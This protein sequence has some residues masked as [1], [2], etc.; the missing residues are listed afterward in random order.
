MTIR[1]FLLSMAAIPALTLPAVHAAV[2]YQHSFS[3]TSGTSLNGIALESRSGIAGGN[4][5]ATW[6][7]S[8]NIKADGSIVSPSGQTSMSAYVPFS[9]VN[10][11]LYTISVDTTATPTA[12]NPTTSLAYTGIALYNGTPNTAGAVGGQPVIAPITRSPDNTPNSLDNPSGPF[13]ILRRWHRTNP[14]TNVGPAITA[15]H[16]GTF[17]PTFDNNGTWR[18]TIQLDTTNAGS[19]MYRWLVEDVGTSALLSE[20]NWTSV[21]SLGSNPINS[22]QLHS[23]GPM[24]SSTFDNFLVTA[25]PEPGAAL[26]GAFALAVAGLRRRR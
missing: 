1:S 11:Y 22:I 6:N 15:N 2:I 25:V 12:V 20:G 14:S 17:E 18:L 16:I 24:A 7:S 4:A 3:G 26:L 13:Q 8:G 10:G 5:G 23:H 21:G 9:P 19:W